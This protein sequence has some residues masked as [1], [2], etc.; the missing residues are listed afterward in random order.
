MDLQRINRIKELLIIAL[1]SDNEFLETLVL[2][3]GNAIDLIH[4]AALR[5]SIDLDFSLEK[6]FLDPDIE[7]LKN[8][9]DQLL[10]TTLNREGYQVFDVMCETRPPEVSADLSEFWGGYRLEFKITTLEKF[11][12]TKNNPRLLRAT[13]EEI[14]SGNKKNF[15]IDISK[16]EFC[17]NK[18]E[19][20]LDG[21]TIYVYSPEMIVCEK[22]RAIC[23]QMP[24]Y[25]KIV[26]SKSQSARAKDFFDIHTLIKHFEI[27][28][29]RKENVVLLQ[30]VFEA[31]KVPLTLLKEIKSF[32]NFHELDFASV[33]DTVKPGKKL[34]S[35]DYYFNFVVNTINQLQSL[36]YE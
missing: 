5:G 35:F 25:G 11:E 19:Q 22:F 6:D 14:G 3:G 28:L 18:T 12:S 24:E 1:F 30:R 26:R 20:E 17:E 27:D 10:N 32:R 29:N 7:R 16:H 15:S 2:K 8:R 4:K 33:K 23:Q 34:R 31:K 9:F 21:Y 13:S 36:G